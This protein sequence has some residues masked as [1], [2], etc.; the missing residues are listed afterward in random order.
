MRYFIFISKMKV[1]LEIVFTEIVT[2]S[3]LPFLTIPLKSINE[4]SIKFIKTLAN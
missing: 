4:C 3:Y 2:L 1:N